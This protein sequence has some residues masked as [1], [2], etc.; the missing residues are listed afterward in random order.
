MVLAILQVNFVIGV[1]HPEFRLET[2]FTIGNEA[3]T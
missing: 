1:R 2:E 3:V